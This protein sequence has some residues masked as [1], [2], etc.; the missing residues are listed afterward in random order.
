MM[1]LPSQE[2]LG[3]HFRLGVH[4]GKDDVD[5]GHRKSFGLISVNGIFRCM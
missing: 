5:G 2:H 1:F 4:E 3:G